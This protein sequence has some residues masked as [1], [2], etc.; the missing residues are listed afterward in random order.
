[1]RKLKCFYFEL[2][3]GRLPRYIE[4]DKNYDSNPFFLSVL[5]IMGTTFDGKYARLFDGET[6][7]IHDR[8]SQEDAPTIVFLHGFAANLDFYH[9]LMQ[10]MKGKEGACHLLSLDWYGFGFSEVYHEKDYDIELYMRQ[11][12]D[13][14]VHVGSKENNIIVG[15]SMGG[16]L[17]AHFASKFPE[18]V[19]E[20]ILLSPSALPYD[21]F[22]ALS[23]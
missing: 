8:H 16:L 7:F 12:R 3:R 11:L 13:L 18:M 5:A 10:H 6:F 20:L 23:K 2:S 9:P 17:A 22:D 15:H 4:M 1:M 14:L 19:N 21:I